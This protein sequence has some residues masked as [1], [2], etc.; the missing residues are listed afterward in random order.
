M[1]RPLFTPEPIK[2][3]AVEV[4]RQLN[5]LTYADA[6]LVLDVAQRSMGSA[7][8]RLHAE[9]VFSPPAFKDMGGDMASTQDITYV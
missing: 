8:E 3:K 1:H 2:A 4:L 7:V 6:L 5:G 9:Q